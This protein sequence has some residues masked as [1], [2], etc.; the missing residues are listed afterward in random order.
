MHG[1]SYLHPDSN[2]AT[3]QQGLPHSREAEEAVLGAVL[4]DPESFIE[5]SNNLHADDFYILRNRWIWEAFFELHEQRIPIDY[6]TISQELEK[7]DRLGRDRRV[8]YL[9]SP[10]NQNPHLA[11]CAEL[12]HHGRTIQCSPENAGCGKSTGSNGI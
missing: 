4:I 2:N 9:M 6:L 11:A 10:I 7:V 12:C 3:D 5:L 1:R 8:A